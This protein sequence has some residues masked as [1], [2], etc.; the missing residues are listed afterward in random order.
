[1]FAKRNVNATVSRYNKSGYRCRRVIAERNF[2]FQHARATVSSSIKRK[3]EK[4]DKPAS[5]KKK[6]SVKV[7]RDEDK[8]EE[9]SPKVLKL[10]KGKLMERAISEDSIPM[11]KE[12]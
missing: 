8:D 6:L 5:V 1:M 12:R 9:L 11:A 3:G 10:S 2:C 7:L 4:K